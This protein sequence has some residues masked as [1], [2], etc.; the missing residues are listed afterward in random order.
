MSAILPEWDVTCLLLLCLL[1]APRTNI[2]CPWGR[3]LCVLG[4]AFFSNLP[5]LPVVAT[6]VWSV[7]TSFLCAPSA[8]SSLGIECWANV[9]LALRPAGL[10]QRQ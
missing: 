8:S 7:K 2:L 10:F 1:F 5:A 3:V 4:S 9:Q 6:I